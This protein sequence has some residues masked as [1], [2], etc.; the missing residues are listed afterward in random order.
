MYDDVF[1]VVNFLHKIGAIKWEQLEP[2]VDINSYG[3]I[4]E[5]GERVLLASCRWEEE[6]DDS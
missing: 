6:R 5:Y 1:N 2:F 3:P 4:V